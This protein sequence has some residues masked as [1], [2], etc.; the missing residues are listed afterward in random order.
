VSNEMGTLHC[1][2]IADKGK[3]NLA[4]ELDGIK[5]NFKK[6]QREKNK[7][8]SGLKLSTADKKDLDFS[9][10]IATWIDLRKKWMME[11]VYY[12][13]TF[14]DD[15]AKYLG[16]SYEE[17]SCYFIAEF[18][19]FLRSG[20]KISAYEVKRRSSEGAFLVF[21]EKS[22]SPDVFYGQDGLDL[23][24][25][26]LHKEKEGQELKG[27]VASTGGK[28]KISGRA[29]I[30]LDPEKDNFS[31]GDILVTSMT[32]VEF[33]PLMRQAKAIITNEGGIACHAA[34]VSRELGIPAIIGTKT[35]MQRLKTG[36]MVEMDL[37]SGVIKIIN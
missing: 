3:E 14:L 20:K 11:V 15:L 4:K 12:T 24:Y 19:D 28:E 25:S 37:K 36:D 30:I 16:L 5:N 18:E 21:S 13:F 29:A 26:G 1:E 9:V 8:L 32:R 22:K 23:L 34:I 35:A 17:I 2:E 33:M 27:F 10:M 31:A 7:I 6:V